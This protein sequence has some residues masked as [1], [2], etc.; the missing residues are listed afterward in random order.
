MRYMST[1]QIIKQKRFLTLFYFISICQVSL[2]WI[3][4]WKSVF[5]AQNNSYSVLKKDTTINFISSFIKFQHAISITW[6]FHVCLMDTIHHKCYKEFRDD[7][8]TIRLMWVCLAA[9]GVGKEGW[10]TSL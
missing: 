10:E 8:S 2:L 7:F 4:F 6:H 3:V 5:I 1:V 9:S